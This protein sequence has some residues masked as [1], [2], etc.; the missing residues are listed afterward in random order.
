MG[1]LCLLAGHA[2]LFPICKHWDAQPRGR[3][4]S[5]DLV[6]VPA[7][8][9]IASGMA[10]RASLDSNLL[11]L[12][13]DKASLSL[14]VVR[15][16]WRPPPCRVTRDLLESHQASRGARAYLSPGKRLM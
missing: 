6:P 1:I 5:S 10:E 7:L 13:L 15:C 2:Y 9:S 11:A 3:R 14:S 8:K 12:G 16:S 4:G